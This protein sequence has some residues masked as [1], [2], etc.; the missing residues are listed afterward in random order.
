MYYHPLN[1]KVGVVVMILKNLDR[2]NKFM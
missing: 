1:L 2:A